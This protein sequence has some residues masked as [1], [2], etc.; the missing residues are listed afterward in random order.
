L[1]ES[2]VVLVP[3]LGLLDQA[4][5]VEAGGRELAL[6]TAAARLRRL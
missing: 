1:L 6:R 5:Q 3:L 4:A 2:I